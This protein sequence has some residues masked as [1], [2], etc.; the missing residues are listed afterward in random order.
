VEDERGER[1]ARVA[2]AN[3][4]DWANRMPGFLHFQVLPVLVAHTIMPIVCFAVMIGASRTRARDSR[5]LLWL[6]PS[7]SLRRSARTCRSAA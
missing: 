4:Q 1:G 7:P 6:A 3:G 5:R 2:R